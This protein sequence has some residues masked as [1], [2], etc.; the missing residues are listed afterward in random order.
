MPVYTGWL[1]KHIQ[2]KWICYITTLH[3][4]RTAQ[5]RKSKSAGQL[6]LLYLFG[7]TL[8]CCCVTHKTSAQ[9]LWLNEKE[10]SSNN[11][12]YIKWQ[13]SWS[14]KREIKMGE[15]EDE[16]KTRKKSHCQNDNVTTYYN[17]MVVQ[18]E[19]DIFYG[20]AFLLSSRFVVVFVT[21]GLFVWRVL[22]VAAAAAQH[23]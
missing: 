23:S 18:K 20:R 9:S 3:S 7:C 1:T 13:P 19:S 17:I 10:T 22:C 8:I 6:E 14:D 15:E 5:H 12:I 21:F 4:K 16:E 2:F 11:R